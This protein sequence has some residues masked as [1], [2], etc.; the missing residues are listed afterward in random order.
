MKKIAL[1]A[2]LAL[3]L[4]ACT[5]NNKE[6][7]ALIGGGVGAGAGALLGGATGVDPVT[8]A[9]VGGAGGAVLGAITGE[10]KHHGHH[11]H[12][13]HRKWDDD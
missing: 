9:L 11:K 6:Q 4:S 5:L 12:R 2:V 7:R 10:D 1:F 3:T 13:R 8:G